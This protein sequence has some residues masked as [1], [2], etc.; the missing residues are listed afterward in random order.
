MIVLALLAPINDSDLPIMTSSEYVPGATWIVSPGARPRHSGTNCFEAASNTA[1][2]YT[3]RGGTRWLGI[4]C[5][6][7][8]ATRNQQHC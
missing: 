8:H 2:I 4:C 1:R 5:E 6:Q 3:Q 7:R